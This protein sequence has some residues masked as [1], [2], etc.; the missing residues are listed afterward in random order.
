MDDN[1]TY[2][3]ET[4][5]EAPQ[6]FPQAAPQPAGSPPGQGPG[7]AS[8]KV[9][10]IAAAS[11]VGVVLLALALIFT[12]GNR[13]PPLT[14]EELL[15][16]GDK[17][18]LEMEYEQAIAAYLR[19]IEIDPQN[20]PARLGLAQ[21]YIALERYDE[22]E[23]RLLEVLELDP[24]NREAYVALQE[25]Y[26]LTG[27]F[28]KLSDL[29]DR[30]RREG[31]EDYIL[32]GEVQGRVVDGLSALLGEE[33][34]LADVR[35]TL[36]L[37]GKRARSLRTD[38][39]G[40][41]FALLR[42]GSFTLSLEKSGYLPYSQAVEVRANEISYMPTL[43]LVPASEAAGSVSGQIID[44]LTGQG[45]PN[46]ALTIFDQSQAVAEALQADEY[47]YYAFS[48]PAGYYSL[49]AE[50]VGYTV[51]QRE[52]SVYGMQDQDNQN[53][54]MTPVLENGEVRIVLTWDL[55]P[56]D[57]DSHLMGP[58]STGLPFHV[59][60]YNQSV[61]E[62]GLLMSNLDLDDTSSYGPET[63]TIYRAAE[64]TYSFV[65][66]DYTNGGDHL[67]TALAAS[68]ANV[69]VYSGDSSV[70]EFNVP[71]SLTGDTWHVFDMVGG[72]LRVPA[73]ASFDLPDFYS[74]EYDVGQTNIE[75]AALTARARM[76]DA[77]V[78]RL[79]IRSGMTA[80]EAADVFG[81]PA[82][83]TSRA[84]LEAD[85]RNGG[86]STDGSGEDLGTYAYW[87]NDSALA[88]ASFFP[89]SLTLRYAAPGS[90][91]ELP[92]GLSYDQTLDEA[93]AGVGLDARAAE[94]LRSSDLEAA[95]AY[96]RA[97]GLAATQR[98]EASLYLSFDGGLLLYQY[99]SSDE[100]YLTL[101]LQSPGYTLT[102]S[103][104]EGY[105]SDLALNLR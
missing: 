81:L 75:G 9:F 6:D 71:P 79:G 58:Q 65:V 97:N 86:L 72:E 35:V 63:T 68:G 1:N 11:I 14:V 10:I 96:C 41:Y 17:Y 4:A 91:A 52:I 67:S 48:Q 43:A 104:F 88:F 23:E 64:G 105:V 59:C 62:E 50:A 102:V 42:A 73:S 21:A 29:L 47:G 15:D 34:S 5:P 22:A 92:F 16:L 70:R 27:D 103:F 89:E 57:L 80:L 74:Q 99:Y 13:Q 39:N 37:N 30:L 83:Y 100:I 28:D 95:L 2:I 61:W 36:Q 84:A 76:T 93:L 82:G 18:L 56:W 19:V 49:S 60:Y 25:L 87:D 38:R 66:H 94:L 101:R 90:Q 53:L 12:L 32:F 31:L 44:S 24:R 45:I 3:P 77:D 7:K 8:K 20:I 26:E 51:M 33:S 69:K 40:L 55:E 54:T 98:G 78:E 85:L 46:A